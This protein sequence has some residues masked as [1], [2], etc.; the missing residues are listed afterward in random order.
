MV[1]QA[2]VVRL[3]D[4]Y[5]GPRL[6]ALLATTYEQMLMAQQIMRARPKRRFAG[7]PAAVFAQ[8]VPNDLTLLCFKLCEQALVL[9]QGAIAASYV[10]SDAADSAVGR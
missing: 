2:L 10:L 8:P 4:L 9:K 1:L 5:I 7:L 6:V 3:V